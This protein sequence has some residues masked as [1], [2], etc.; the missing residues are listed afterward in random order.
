MTKS[1]PEKRPAHA[2]AVKNSAELN[3]FRKLLDGKLSG[4]ERWLISGELAMK[5]ANERLSAPLHKSA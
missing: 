1:H 2:K 5:E 3:H 4:I